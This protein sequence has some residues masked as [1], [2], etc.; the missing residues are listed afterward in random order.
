MK[1]LTVAILIL[2]VIVASLLI[3][4]F[5]GSY[6]SAK[7][8]T[9]PFVRKF[10]LLRPEA[11]IVIH[12]REEVRLS[13]TQDVIA[14][15]NKVRSKI[16]SVLLIDNGRVDVLASAIN[17]SG[18]G[19]FMTIK[20]PLANV[21]LAKLAVRLEDGKIGRVENVVMDPATNI[22]LVKAQIADVPPAAFADSVAATAG[23]RVLFVGTTDTIPT[24][25]ASFTSF[26]EEVKAVQSSDYVG[27]TLGIQQVPGITLGHVAVDTDGDVLGMWD[28][29]HIIPSSV[30][31]SSTTNYFANN[32]SIVRPLFGFTYTF[33]S[34]SESKLLNV[35]LGARVVK[36]GEAQA[37]MVGG[38]AERAG[39]RL[40]D[41]ITEINGIKIAQSYQ[42]EQQLEKMKP[43]ESAT[44]TIVRSGNTTQLTINAGELK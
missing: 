24:F 33:V 27:R 10:N 11:P 1:K 37:V 8:S 38:P 39:L 2:A 18:D 36:A 3:Q 15:F 31:R 32:G 17:I 12:T 40:D 7:I 21:P 25:L 13:D 5:F 22:A 9:L 4:I 6:L 23:Q 43:G 44:V 41:T 29:T 28:G 42:L 34:E 19:V 14:A 35:P 20:T 16:S 30:L 26:Q